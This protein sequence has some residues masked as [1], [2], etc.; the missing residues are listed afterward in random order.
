MFYLKILDVGCGKNKLKNSVGIDFYK[1]SDI[2]HDLNRFPYPVKANSFDKIYSRH[3]LEHLAFF[4]ET[5][6]EFYRI[7]KKDGLIEII[8]PFYASSGASHPT[9]KRFFNYHSF[10][11][12]EPN[13]MHRWEINS[14]ARFS[15]LKINYNFYPKAVKTKFTGISKIFFWLPEMLANKFPLFYE[16]FFANILPAYEIQFILKPIK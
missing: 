4:E 7:I 14:K 9:H 16:R 13:E 10:D 5:M 1:D 8:V 11:F 15:V 3:C 6:D 12:F 2:I